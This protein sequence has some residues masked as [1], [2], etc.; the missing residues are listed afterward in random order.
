MTVQNYD[1]EFG[2]IVATVP[3][4]WMKMSPSKKR[5][6]TDEQRKE[7]AERLAKSRSKKSV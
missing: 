5:E 2:S 4:K 7:L 6:L 1:K 3:A